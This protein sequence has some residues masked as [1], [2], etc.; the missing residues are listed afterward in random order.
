MI[1]TIVLSCYL[2]LILYLWGIF[3]TKVYSL[4]NISH[5]KKIFSV[6]IINILLAPIT[7][8]SAIR[9]APDYFSNVDKRLVEIREAMFELR[10]LN[11]GKAVKMLSK[12]LDGE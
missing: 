11:V 6:F 8:F 9:S 1:L 10:N 12:I 5:K 4:T 2:L 7:M 3:A